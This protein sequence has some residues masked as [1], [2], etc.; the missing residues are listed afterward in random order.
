MGDRSKHRAIS[1]ILGSASMLSVI[2]GCTSAGEAPSN[3]KKVESESEAT[4]T[5]QPLPAVHDSD[6]IDANI[7]DLNRPD[8]VR[9]IASSLDEMYP[10][11][12]MNSV[13][14]SLRD[15]VD[16]E[17]EGHPWGDVPVNG[18][19]LYAREVC[20][21]IPRLYE[22]PE[23]YTKMR[24][25]SGAIFMDA[26]TTCTVWSNEDSMDG[27]FHATRLSRINEQINQGDAGSEVA[28]LQARYICPQLIE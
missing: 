26:L 17:E 22:D 11:G 20:G 9:L 15:S 3:V 6:C 27:E 16:G 10:G 12:A 2:V 4:K 28:L 1:L 23:I 13:T 19:A 25:T 7:G 18:L 24:S 5:A 14:N 21:V 8:L